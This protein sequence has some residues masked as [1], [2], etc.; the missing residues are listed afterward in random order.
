MSVPALPGCFTLGDT[1][2]G[3]LVNAKD[4]I[5]LYLEDLAAPGDPILVETQRP[6]L[7]SVTVAA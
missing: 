3:C 5:G 4:V 7:L 2:E 1:V 6:R